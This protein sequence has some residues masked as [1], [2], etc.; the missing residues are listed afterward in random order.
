MLGGEHPLGRLSGSDA[1]VCEEL[2]TLLSGS[3]T[4]STDSHTKLIQPYSALYKF[5]A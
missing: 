4:L 3:F 5:P 1:N 2:L